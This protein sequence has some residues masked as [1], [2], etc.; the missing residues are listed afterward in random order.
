MQWG[1]GGFNHVMNGDS[2]KEPSPT[3]LLMTLL[4]LDIKMWWQTLHEPNTF[5]SNV[6]WLAQNNRI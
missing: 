3:F 5:H 1:E 6:S 2:D 4:N